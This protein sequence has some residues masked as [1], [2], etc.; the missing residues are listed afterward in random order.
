[1]QGQS[2]MISIL[3]YTYLFSAD[4]TNM[5]TQFLMDGRDTPFQRIMW[6]DSPDNLIKY[7]ELTIVTIGVASSPYLAT[8]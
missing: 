1:M 7:Y 4:I 8:R 3:S 5:Y 2:D 6:R